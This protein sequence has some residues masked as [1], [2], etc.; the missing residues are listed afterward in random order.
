MSVQGNTLGRRF[1]VDL[2]LYDPLEAKSAAKLKVEELDV[3]V[4][5]FD[6][7]FVNIRSLAMQDRTYVSG[8]MLR[9]AEA[10]VVTDLR[11]SVIVGKEDFENLRIRLVDKTRL[12]SSAW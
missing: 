8:K 10:M 9:S 4:D 2:N 6:T 5:C 12:E 1:D 3:V 7:E 11:R